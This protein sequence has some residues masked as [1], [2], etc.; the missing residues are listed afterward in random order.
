M[1]SSS[2]SAS[3]DAETPE[4][5]AS[6]RRE[7]DFED[8]RFDRDKNT[9]YEEAK[10]EMREEKDNGYYSRDHFSTNETRKEYELRK[11]KEFRDKNDGY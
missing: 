9:S 4:A 2:R 8:W 11:L 6:R 10:R 5:I 1:S 7:E 3:Y